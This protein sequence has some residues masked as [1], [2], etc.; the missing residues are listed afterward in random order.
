MRGGE[1]GVWAREGVVDVRS[2]FSRRDDMLEGCKYV[3]E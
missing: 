1:V 2:A 3:Q